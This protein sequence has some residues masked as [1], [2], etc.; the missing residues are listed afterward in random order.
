MDIFANLWLGL[1]VA[2]TMYN[3]FYCLVGV[4]LGLSLIHI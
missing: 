1:T 3:L 2:G 4:F